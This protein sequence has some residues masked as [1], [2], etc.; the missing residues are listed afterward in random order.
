[1]AGHGDRF[2]TNDF[3]EEELHSVKFF[4]K[5]ATG[6]IS[7]KNIYTVHITEIGGKLSEPETISVSKSRNALVFKD[8]N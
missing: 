7:N 4:T 6:Y 1:M 2:Q 5:T 3:R 8:L